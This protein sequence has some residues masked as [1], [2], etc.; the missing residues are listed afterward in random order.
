M[1]QSIPYMLHTCCIHFAYML[2]TC[3]CFE[4]LQSSCVS[5]LALGQRVC[6]HTIH[7]LSAQKMRMSHSDGHKHDEYL[8]Y[9]HSSADVTSFI[10]MTPHIYTKNPQTH[11]TR[12][13]ACVYVCVCSA[14]QRACVYACVRVDICV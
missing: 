3:I 12:V 9:S 13:L 10:T 7:S 14:W 11:L 2:H 6:I 4:V 5:T 8:A 1:L